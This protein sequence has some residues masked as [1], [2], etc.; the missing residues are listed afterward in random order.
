MPRLYLNIGLILK[1][2][3]MTSRMVTRKTDEKFV[4]PSLD[5]HTC[6]CKRTNLRES[7][8]QARWRKS[9]CKTKP[10]DLWTS[11]GSNNT[12]DYFLQGGNIFF[13]A[14]TS[15]S[16]TRTQK[17][18]WISV[19]TYP[20]WPSSQLFIRP[21][22][23]DLT[24]FTLLGAHQLWVMALRFRSNDNF[25]NFHILSNITWYFPWFP[26]D[27]STTTLQPAL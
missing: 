13:K 2:L 24:G 11:H 20:I 1:L 12:L 21:V 23:Q 6:L 26:L 5:F 10:W 4:M 18:S 3:Q 9:L 17:P 16:K 15:S 25:S 8:K 14:G 19:K 22:L 7:L 27:V